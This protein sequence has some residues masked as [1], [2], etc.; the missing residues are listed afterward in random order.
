MASTDAE[1]LMRNTM[2][3]ATYDR[4]EKDVSKVR[5]DIAAL[6]DHITDAVNALGDAARRQARR[7]YKQTVDDLSERSGAMMD[8]AQDAASD[9]EDRLEDVIAQRPLATIGL[10]LGVGILI[11]AMW[12]R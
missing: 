2:G 8:A 12:R 6:T 9:L 1:S 10:A 4:L 11:G 5:S 7:G 3:D